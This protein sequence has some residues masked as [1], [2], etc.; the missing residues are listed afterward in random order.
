MQAG[1]II[2]KIQKRHDNFGNPR[3]LFFWRV[4]NTH[5]NA[6]SVMTHHLYIID[7]SLFIR[8][9]IWSLHL[10]RE[11]AGFFFQRFTTHFTIW[12]RNYGLFICLVFFCEIL[13]HSQF[14]RFDKNV[15]NDFYSSR[16]RCLGEPRMFFVSRLVSL[17]SCRVQVCVKCCVKD[18]PLRR[19]L[20]HLISRG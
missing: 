17:F 12:K 15:H 6:L 19:W 16:R 1:T 7:G 9:L 10:I 4:H 5:N 11:C 3:S 8:L 13:Q 20:F 18:L 14:T 2:Y